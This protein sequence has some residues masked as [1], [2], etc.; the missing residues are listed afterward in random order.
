[1]AVTVLVEFH[2]K[3]EN[4]DQF[5]SLYEEVIPDTYTYNGFQSIEFVKNQDDPY[6]FFLIEKW[7]SR[8]HYEAYF[9]WRLETGLI[10]K[11]AAMS[12]QAPIIRYYDQMSAY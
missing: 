9:A 2:C 12:S 4:I 5:K 8:Q 6:N 10:D 7:D 11:L 3:P 1:M